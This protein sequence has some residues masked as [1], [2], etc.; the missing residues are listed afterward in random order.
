[1][2]VSD[3]PERLGLRSAR[4]LQERVQEAGLHILSLERLFLPN[5]G[6]PKIVAIRFTTREKTNRF[7]CTDWFQIINREFRG[8]W[9]CARFFRVQEGCDANVGCRDV[10]C[11]NGVCGFG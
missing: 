5:M 3:F 2:I 6:N 7:L 1:M 8:A 11:A 9:G 4:W 10:L